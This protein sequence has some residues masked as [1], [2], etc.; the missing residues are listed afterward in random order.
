MEVEESCWDS[1]LLRQ[2][3]LAQSAQPAWNVGGGKEAHLRIL[4]SDG[5]GGNGSRRMKELLRWHTAQGS[6]AWP[7][8]FREQGKW[9]KEM[10]LTG[11]V[12]EF[13]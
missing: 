4:S 13:L 1:R 2:L 11:M 8:G 6:L 5:G 12:Q 10:N 9:M 7:N 3:G